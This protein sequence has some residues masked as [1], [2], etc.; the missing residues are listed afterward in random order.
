MYNLTGGFST[1]RH[2]LAAL[3]LGESLL[4]L[5]VVQ[6][7]DEVPVDALVQVD[8]PDEVQMVELVGAVHLNNCITLKKS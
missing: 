1:Y 3:W 5:Q 6:H 8:G 7:V 2:V 4:S